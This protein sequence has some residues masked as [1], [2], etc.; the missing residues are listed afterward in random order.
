MEH[1]RPNSGRLCTRRR[2]ERSTL[3]QMASET[4]TMLVGRRQHAQ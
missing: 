1:T 4:L 3:W 2:N